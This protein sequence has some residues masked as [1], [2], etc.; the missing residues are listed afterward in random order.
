VSGEGNLDLKLICFA[1]WLILLR[2]R[3]HN[4]FGNGQH[5]SDPVRISDVEQ[6]GFRHASG[7]LAWRKVYNE[8]RLL[9]FDLLLQR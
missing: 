8:Q 7:H 1:R 2:S 6:H 5:G 3:Q 4:R 9:A